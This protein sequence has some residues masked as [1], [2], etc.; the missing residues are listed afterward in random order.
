MAPFDSVLPMT[1]H[2]RR[3]RERAVLDQRVRRIER[4]LAEVK[5]Q[6]PSVAEAMLRKIAETIND[7][8]GIGTEPRSSYIGQKSVLAPYIFADLR[9]RHERNVLE[10]WARD[11]KPKSIRAVRV[12][13]AKEVDIASRYYKEQPKPKT[14]DEGR[15][16]HDSRN[17]H[18]LRGGTAGRRLPGTMAEIKQLLPRLT[19]RQRVVYQGMVLDDPPRSRAEIARELGIRHLNQVSEILKQA[20]TK[21]KKWLLGKE[22]KPK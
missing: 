8:T 11:G 10:W 22:Q 12:G 7:Y 19:H 16:R 5:G 3:E 6:P 2:K 17:R 9:R 1:K 4:R 15:A 14:W 18:Y 13:G 20:G 21:M